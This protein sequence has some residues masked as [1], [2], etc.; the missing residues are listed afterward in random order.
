MAV[1]KTTDIDQITGKLKNAAANPIAMP[2]TVVGDAS[3]NSDLKATPDA[4]KAY[5]DYIKQPSP[6]AVTSPSPLVTNEALK[7]YADYNSKNKSAL[8]AIN[9]N[10]DNDIDKAT[11]DRNS[12]FLSVNLARE[13]ANRQNAASL[14]SSG[15]KAADFDR[16][17]SIAAPV[18]P[19]ATAP[20]TTTTSDNNTAPIAIPVP[21]PKATATYTEPTTSAAPV[22]VPAAT[23]MALASANPIYKTS[24]NSY[25]DT[26]NANT[27]SPSASKLA[28]F[29]AAYGENGAFKGRDMYDSSVNSDVQYELNRKAAGL[30]YNKSVINGGNAQA[31][32]A[33]TSKPANYLKEYDAAGNINED[34]TP[35]AV[36]TAYETPV[37]DVTQESSDRVAVDN[38]QTAPIKYKTTEAIGGV[39]SGTSNGISDSLVGSAGTDT[40]T[41]VIATQKQ[42]TANS[43]PATAQPIATPAKGTFSVV[44]NGATA[45]SQPVINSG[46]AQPIATPSNTRTP[47][48]EESF[49]QTPIKSNVLSG[50]QDSE[51]FKRAV[52]ESQQAISRGISHPKDTGA[53]KAAQIAEENLKALFGF[54]VQGNQKTQLEQEQL[55]QSDLAQRR[56]QR[57]KHFASLLGADE[58]GKTLAQRQAELE[59]NMQQFGVTSDLARQGLEMKSRPKTQAEKEDKLIQVGENEDG[60]KKYELE[61]K[62]KADLIAQHES[63]RQAKAKAILEPNSGAT[64]EQIKAAKSLLGVK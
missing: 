35:I 3:M 15:G 51:D 33:P 11:A 28:D 29:R 5:A 36:T 60:T 6:Q 7:A 47:P 34:K 39:F 21:I 53:V 9:K 24:A 42:Q 1:P 62:V 8:P 10:N 64:P 12:D 41:P 27:S 14:L 49:Q 45:P 30:S 52:K 56:D 19:K 48:Q 25:G 20:I 59:Q 44:S 13:E 23:Q 43:N 55:G 18:Q 31:A 26:V 61:S 32:A 40:I 2:K 46:I 58:S 50:Y 16:P 38:K 63:E 37:N 57:T 17:A 54:D 4:L 22:A